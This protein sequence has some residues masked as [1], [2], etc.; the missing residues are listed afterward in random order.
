MFCL[1]HVS[2]L[3]MRTCSQLLDTFHFFQELPA[4]LVPLCLML[5]TSAEKTT[6]LPSQLLLVGYF[7]LSSIHFFFGGGKST[8]FALFVPA[9]V[10]CIYNGYMQVSYPSNWVT[11]PCFITGSVLGLVGWLVNVYSDHIL[12]NLRKPGERGYKILYQKIR[13]L[14]PAG[15]LWPIKTT[16]WKFPSKALIL[17]L[18]LHAV[19]NHCLFLF[20]TC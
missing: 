5:W 13:F 8:S 4:F 7:A 9:F 2:Q 18:C 3:Q 17:N 19:E 12:R 14:L 16:T 11:S 1:F 20:S 10:F 15:T 6:H